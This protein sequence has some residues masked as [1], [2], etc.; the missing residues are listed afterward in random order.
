MLLHFYDSQN[1]RT[2]RYTD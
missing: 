2:T 1:R